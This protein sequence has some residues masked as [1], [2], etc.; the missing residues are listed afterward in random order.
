MTAQPIQLPQPITPTLRIQLGPTASAAL[1]A[2]GH[3][4]LVVSPQ[5]HPDDPTRYA[6]YCYTLPP[7][8][9]RQLAA[10]LAGSHHAVKNRPAKASFTN[11]HES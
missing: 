9:T 7:E 11:I 4:Y 2:T 10:I 5:T 6:I 3:D 8:I 1:A